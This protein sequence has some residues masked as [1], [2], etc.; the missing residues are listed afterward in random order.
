MSE[1]QMSIFLFQKYQLNKNYIKC[2]SNSVDN[3]K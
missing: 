2:D 1:L 3:V